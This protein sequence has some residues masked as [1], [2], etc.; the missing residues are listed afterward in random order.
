[1]ES[2]EV[3]FDDYASH[4]RTSGNKWCHRFG[5]PLIMASILGMLTRIVV[6]RWGGLYV[7]GAMALMAI[8]TFYYLLIA[9]FLA[10]VM[11]AI[12][13]VFYLVAAQLPMWLLVTMFVL[14]WILQFV[15]HGVFEK[16]RPAFLKNVAHLLIGPLWI[17]R[18]A[19][20]AL[21]GTDST[22]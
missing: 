20:N 16:Q 4:H 3:M 12:S 19:G 21:S 10:I 13:I 2:A 6:L 1:M 22:K 8:A 15:G 17:V 7:D 11:L 5:I 9:P 18:E 14:G